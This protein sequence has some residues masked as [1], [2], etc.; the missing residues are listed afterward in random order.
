MLQAYQILLGK[1]VLYLI[2]L[3]H[4]LRAYS[5]YSFGSAGV[6][7]RYRIYQS[8]DLPSLVFHL[9]GRGLGSC[10]LLVQVVSC[11]SHTVHISAR[12]PIINLE[13]KVKKGGT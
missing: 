5:R 11:C 1:T 8:H 2:S 3:S 12:M 9:P 4:S 6:L 10:N 13:F 7:V